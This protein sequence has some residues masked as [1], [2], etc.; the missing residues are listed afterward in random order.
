MSVAYST[1]VVV[2]FAEYA[3]DFFIIIMIISSITIIICYIIII[4]IIITIIMLS[5]L[6]LLLSLSSLPLGDIAPVAAA[7]AP[8]RERLVE[9]IESGDL[10]CMA[11]NIYQSFDR[12]GYLSWSHGEIHDFATAV[13]RHYCLRPPSDRCLLQLYAKFD[14][15]RK[16]DLNA[17]EC[18]CLVDVLF[19]VVFHAEA[20]LI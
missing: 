2:E 1:G 10:M 11:L 15:G 3:G 4:I 14:Q 19:R 16:S 8:H 6:L 13:F 17:S 9:T 12:G 7:N 18:L 5:L 20:S